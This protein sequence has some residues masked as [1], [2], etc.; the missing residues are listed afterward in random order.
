MLAFDDERKWMLLQQQKTK[1]EL[2]K[3]QNVVKKTPEDYINDL[4]N[5]QFD[6]AYSSLLKY[7]EVD[8]RTETLTWVKSFL[9]ANGLVVMLDVINALNAKSSYVRYYIITVGL[10]MRKEIYSTTVFEL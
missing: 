9:N 1:E 4:K 6:T 3:L 8:L 10:P 2:Q 7:L 5:P